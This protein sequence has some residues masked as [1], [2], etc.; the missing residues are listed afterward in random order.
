MSKL[1]KFKALD[2]LF[3]RDGTPY[4]AG[5]GG[6]GQVAANFPPYMT[7]LQG[8]IRTTLASGQGWT[9][10]EPKKWPE[11]LGTPE[12][13][14]KLI[15]R[16]PYLFKGEEVLF[17]APLLYLQK[18][19]I[20]N[21]SC[22]RM[23]PGKAI[24]CDLG[25]KRLPQPNQPLEGAKAPEGY[26][27]KKS[28]LGKILAG[29]LPTKTDIVDSRD[30]WKPEKRTGI[31]LNLD[32]R[33]S[34]DSMIYSCVQ[35]RPE[36]DVSLGVY[37]SG[38]P[39]EWHVQ[40]PPVARLGGEGRLAA[41]KINNNTGEDILPQPELHPARGIINFTVVLITPGFYKDTS[42][43][44][45]NG[46]PG[47]PGDC[48][49]ACVGRAQKVGGWDI[50]N[51]CPRPLHPVIPAGSAWFF[52]AEEKEL[53]NI[54]SLHGKCLGLKEEYG[55]GQIVIGCWRDVN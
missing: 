29:E 12:E 23:V 2:S 22:T 28:G 53:G 4:N 20:E 42:H 33:T 48:I 43:V 50:V 31:E 37:V 14:G 55:F 13:L 41:I 49:S 46:P 24:E 38:V 9:P 35:V 8:A 26:W 15:L 45:E 32:T 6:Q 27:L 18:I 19:E 5:E 47:I 39:D 25:K 44:I 34:Q 51:R 40:L 30:L 17:P 21:I 1:W 36:K 11:V 52:Q 10:E 7:T 54:R 16:G 3:F